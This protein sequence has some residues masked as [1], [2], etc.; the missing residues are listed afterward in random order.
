MVRLIPANLFMA[1]R[2]QL[3]PPKAVVAILSS[4]VTQTSV[5][6]YSFQAYLC[7]IFKT[8]NTYKLSEVGFKIK[9][10]VKEKINV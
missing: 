9:K 2:L 10:Y 1:S 8:K 7:S 3:A 5:C 4:V 6:V